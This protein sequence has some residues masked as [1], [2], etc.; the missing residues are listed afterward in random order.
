M[1]RRLTEPRATAEI[2]EE[3]K[4]HRE[5]VLRATPAPHRHPVEKGGGDVA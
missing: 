2:E 5:A 4:R 1:D 3:A